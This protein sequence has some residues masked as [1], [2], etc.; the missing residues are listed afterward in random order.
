MHATAQIGSAYALTRL[1]LCPPSSLV[2]RSCSAL[3]LV[4]PFAIHAGRPYDRSAATRCDPER[5]CDA[6]K[7]M[8]I[9]KRSG[10]DQDGNTTSLDS[11]GVLG[12]VSSFMHYLGS[13]YS[14]L[15]VQ[16]KL[17]LRPI[18]IATVGIVISYCFHS[19]PRN[20]VVSNL[21]ILI[22]VSLRPT[23]HV[24]RPSRTSTWVRQVRR[25]HS[26]SRCGWSSS[27]WRQSWIACGRSCQMNSASSRC[28]SASC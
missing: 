18:A 22:T 25:S 6:S 21:L 8:Q 27:S 16:E 1:V 4:L 24:H 23:I 5:D 7:D 14:W 3:I 28:W 2:P 20:V 17:E 19:S 12:K 9:V 15:Y 13:H 10:T 26:C 11:S